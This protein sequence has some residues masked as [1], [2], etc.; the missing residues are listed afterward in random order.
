MQEKRV[1]NRV[2]ITLII[3]AVLALCGSL[4][5]IKREKIDTDKMAEISI[6]IE[7]LSKQKNAAEIQIEKLDGEYTENVKNSDAWQFLITD[8]SGKVYT[9]IFP[10]F[11]SYSLPAVILISADDFAGGGRRLG[12]NR[13]SEMVENGWSCCISYDGDDLSLAEQLDN[14]RKVTETGDL[15]M[16]E[17]IYFGDDMYKTEYD[18]ILLNYG[19]T[20]VVHDSDEEYLSSARNFEKGK[21]WHVGLTPWISDDDAIETFVADGTNTVYEINFDET[22]KALFDAAKFEEMLLDTEDYREDGSLEVVDFA[23]AYKN[24]EEAEQLS[25][26]YLLKREEYEKQIRDADEK[27]DELCTEFGG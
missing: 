3:I 8:A 13:I 12:T 18:E 9:E 2:A 27:I 24:R 19:I 14:I 1:L 21:I 7:N 22:D 5:F 16:P 25:A 11:K 17:A 26:D 20:T 15:E 4:V 10:L 6:Q 23:T